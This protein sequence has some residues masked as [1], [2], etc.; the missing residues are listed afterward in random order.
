MGVLAGFDLRARPAAVLG[1]LDAFPR[2]ERGRRFARVDGLHRL[3]H[4]ITH[5]CNMLHV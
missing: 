2:A 1:A 4:V 5:V 3:L